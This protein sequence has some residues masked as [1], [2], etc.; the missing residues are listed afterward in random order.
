M[1][2]LALPMK[3]IHA[4][5]KI[6]RGFLW[7]GKKEA[8]G[9]NCSVAWTTVCTPKWAG[10]L[11]IPDLAW[12][13]VAL[14][15]RWPWLQRVDQNRPWSEFDIK[16]PKDSTAL[17][18]AATKITEGDRGLTLF[19]ED[20]WMDGYRIAEFAPLIYAAVPP[21]KRR[22]RT[23]KEAITT[24]VWASDIKPDLGP[25]ALW[26]YLNLWPRVQE[27]TLQ[28]D[29]QDVVSWCWEPGGRYSARSAYAAKFAG[30]EVSATSQFTW[31]S[32]APLRYR[33][34]LW[35][36]MKNRHSGELYAPQ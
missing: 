11:G 36:A 31:K 34:F 20:R 6:I 25:Q 7:C 33:F 23:L 17:C 28:D 8:N 21:L 2:A 19:W 4:I 5:N 10:G 26:Q 35:L 30:R 1:L 14:Q 15:A 12:L 29:V 32:R 16:V 22:T 13:N 3:T 9:G 24:G 27:V 18:N